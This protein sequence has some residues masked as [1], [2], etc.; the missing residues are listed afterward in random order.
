[1][2]NYSKVIFSSALL[3]ILASFIPGTSAGI[4][5][6]TS[7]CDGAYCPY[8]PVTTTTTTE[9]ETPTTT[10]SSILPTN[11]IGCGETAYLF[12]EPNNLFQQSGNNNKWGWELIYSLSTTP[13]TTQYQVYA[14]AGKDVRDPSRIA[15]QAT[16]VRNSVAQTLTIS[17]DMAPNVQYVDLM[18]Q[19]Q[20][21]LNV[22]VSPLVGNAAPGQ[23]KVF[24]TKL[25][26][27]VLVPQKSVSFVVSY[28][29]QSI[30]NNEV[31]IILH[32]TVNGSNCIKFI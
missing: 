30:V 32:S 24:G 4:L 9:I 3:A 5:P 1:M 11:I 14:A 22:Q 12:G 25:T 29:G 17:L 16:I 23:F 2:L 18:G 27:N 10:T 20:V 8:D 19:P 21:Q 7:Y 13:A 31:Y 6:Q 26:P 28:A 15:G